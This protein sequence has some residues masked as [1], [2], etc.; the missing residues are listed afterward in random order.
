M[1][2][3]PIPI[4]IRGTTYASARIAAEA[5]GISR[6]R[7]YQALDEGTLDQ[8][9][10]SESGKPKPIRIEGVVFPSR[11]AAAQ[12]YAIPSTTLSHRIRQGLDPLTGKKP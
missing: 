4:R 11:T 2:T 6:T 7:I 3:K 8:C 12:Y 9:G 10:L 5:L 1:P